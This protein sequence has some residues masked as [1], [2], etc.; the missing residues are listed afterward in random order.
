MGV[1]NKLGPSLE[2]VL[3]ENGGWRVDEPTTWRGTEYKR[4]DSNDRPYIYVQF[5]EGEQVNFGVF[6]DKDE[7][8]G[9]SFW[10]MRASFDLDDQGRV[11]QLRPSEIEVGDLP[12]GSRWFNA[13]VYLGGEKFVLTYC[14]DEEDQGRA[15]L[16]EVGVQTKAEFFERT[17]MLCGNEY[18]DKVRQLVEAGLSAWVDWRATVMRCVSDPALPAEELATGLLV[19]VDEGIEED[20]L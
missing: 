2:G 19:A 12:K 13:W 8:R 1:D 7:G 16:R 18:G 15:S 6:L 10:G 11:G 20:R 5:R 9:L 17:R 4:G 14:Q 3:G